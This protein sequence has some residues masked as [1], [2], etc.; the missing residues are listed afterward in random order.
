MKNKCT[1]Y[2]SHYDAI[3]SLKP[4]EQLALYKAIFEYQFY[5]N[6]IELNGMVKTLFEVFR[7][8][9]DFNNARKARYTKTEQNDDKLQ[10]KCH[11]NVCE[12]KT[13]NKQIVSPR[14]KSYELRVK[15]LKEKENSKRKN[16]SPPSLQEI[17]EYCASR[18]NT[19]DPQRFFDF[20]S[21]KDWMI[22]KNKMKDWKAAVRTWESREKKEQ[23]AV[24]D[25]DIIDNSKIQ[26]SDEE[27]E[28]YF[29]EE[30]EQNKFDRAV[31]PGH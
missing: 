14:V 1:F 30:Y 9:I 12:T 25:Y 7:P 6:E 3:N 8:T 13:N 31:G 20:Y 26:I 5:D 2:K 23:I 24:V 11:Q 16:F 21:S 10:T 28:S 29:K 17:E 18:K 4:K 19:V 15:S 27:Y 22:G